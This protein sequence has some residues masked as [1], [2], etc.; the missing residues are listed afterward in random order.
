VLDEKNVSA[1]SMWVKRYV[2]GTAKLYIKKASFQGQPRLVCG[3]DTEEWVLSLYKNF[4]SSGIL[5]ILQ[6]EACCFTAICNWTLKKEQLPPQPN[7]KCQCI[8]T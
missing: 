4:T 3:Y 5:S 8:L 2:M 7:M 1:N 6:G